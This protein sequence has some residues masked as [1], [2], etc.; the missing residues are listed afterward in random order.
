MKEITIKN[1]KKSLQ[2]ETVQKENQ[3]TKEEKDKTKTI[4][5]LATLFFFKV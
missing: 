1:T 3:R 2:Q 4:H 5:N